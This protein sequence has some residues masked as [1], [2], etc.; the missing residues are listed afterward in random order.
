M[1]LSRS[2]LGG[3]GGVSPSGT[4]WGYPPFWISGGSRGGTGTRARPSGPNF[5]H[6][7][8]VFRKIWSN[9]MLAPY[10]GLASHVWEIVDPP[11]WMRV[12]PPVGDWMGV[13]PLTEWMLYP[14]PPPSNWVVLGTGYVMGCTTRGSRIWSGGG[15]DIF[16][17]NLRMQQSKPILAGVQS[18]P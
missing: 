12:H 4:G 2:A 5:F 9:S 3:G 6:F 18:P 15:A 11:L 13:P 1:S 7:H 8:A 10:V 14:S 16:P 17:E